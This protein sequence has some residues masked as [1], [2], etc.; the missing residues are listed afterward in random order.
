MNNNC[1]LQKSCNKKDGEHLSQ[2]ICMNEIIWRPAINHKY[3]APNNNNGDYVL[4]ILAYVNLFQG[5]LG[6]EYSE[7][8]LPFHSSGGILGLHSLPKTTQ[9][10]P[11][12]MHSG[13]L[14]SQPLA[15]QPDT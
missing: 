13:E 7:M 15:L 5:F 14:N 10:G 12:R 3:I 4:L 9:A 6:T 8:V 1:K 11:S 2:C